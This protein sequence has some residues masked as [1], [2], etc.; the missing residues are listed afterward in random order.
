MC[1]INGVMCRIQ[2]PPLDET[3][4]I[5]AFL[6][7]TRR[8]FPVKFSSSRVINIIYRPVFPQIMIDVKNIYNNVQ[9]FMCEDKGKGTY[10]KNMVYV[11]MKNIE[12]KCRSKVILKKNQK[13]FFNIFTRKCCGFF[14]RYL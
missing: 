7:H 10:V 13:H 11:K 4:R 3:R 14:L 1:D 9:S 2:S 12:K 5:S 8:F 6:W